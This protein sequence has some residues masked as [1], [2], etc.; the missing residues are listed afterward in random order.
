MWLPLLTSFPQ[1]T[2]ICCSVVFRVLEV[3]SLEFIREL[4]MLLATSEPMKAAEALML[5][6]V[7]LALWSLPEVF[8]VKTKG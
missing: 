3:G 4:R 2:E 8:K 1:R 6:L 5:S 7:A